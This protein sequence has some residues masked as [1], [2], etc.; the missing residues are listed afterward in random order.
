ML[1]TQMQQI[2]EKLASKRPVFHSEADFQHALAWQIQHEIPDAQ[3]RLEKPMP[4]G[5][6]TAYLDLLVKTSTC[7]I[8]IELKYKTSKTYFQHGDEEFKLKEQGAQDL[9]RY[10]FVTDIKRLENY[11]KT[12]NQ[13]EGFAIFLTNDKS[14]W[15]EPKRNKA[16][17]MMYRI[18]DGKVI[19]GCLTWGAQVPDGTSGSRTNNII[20]LN[21]KYSVSWQPY[22]KI[23]PSDRDAF[24]F[25]LLHIKQLT[26]T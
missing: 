15:S 10:D 24:K 3:I 5:D 13:S 2:L 17:D 12:N 23:S 8:A 18:H 1:T 26:M 19:E 25:L 20:E 22:P 9:G 7:H 4:L 14:Y 21:G 11:V 16:N 6:S